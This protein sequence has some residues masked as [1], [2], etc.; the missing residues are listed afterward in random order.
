MW[1]DRRWL[2]AAVLAAASLPACAGGKMKAVTKRAK[3]PVRL[4]SRN[5]RWLWCFIPVRSVAGAEGRAEVYNE[6]FKLGG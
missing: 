3:Q 2:L 6:N 4:R 5:N 1:R